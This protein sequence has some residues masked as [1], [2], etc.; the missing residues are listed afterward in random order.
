MNLSHQPR[1]CMMCSSLYVRANGEVPCWDSVGEE[2]IL[3]IVDA[4]VLQKEDSQLFHSPELQFIR[5]S[6]MYGQDPFPGLC[7]R[8]AVHGHGG[9][10]TL[11]RPTTLDVLHIEASF[12]CH[13][14]CPQCIPPSERRSM[15]NPPYDMPLELF[16]SVLG[17][18]QR[19]GVLNIRVVHFEGRGDPLVNPRLPQMIEMAKKRYPH[20]LTMITTHGSYPY[21]PELLISGLDELRVSVDGAFP[22]NYSKYRVGGDLSKVLEFLR[23][24]LHDKQRLGVHL[25]VEW[26]YILFEWNDTKAEM[27]EAARLADALGARLSFVRTHSPGASLRFADRNVLAKFIRS[28]A[29]N[30]CQDSTYQ[31]KVADDSSCVD[32]L[33]GEHI[34]ALELDSD[35]SRKKPTTR[36][37]RIR[38]RLL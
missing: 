21:K 24:L 25:H 1:G 14:S 17:V 30:A 19:E 7:E 20:A 37:N 33:I 11:S 23:H 31:L 10:A 32:P 9:P 6:F 2:Q 3:Q 26:K 27:I 38:S 5:Q 12:L 28:H 22:E 29:P 8:C 35:P 34:T 13:L 18:L 36:W 15:R 4:Q 16:E